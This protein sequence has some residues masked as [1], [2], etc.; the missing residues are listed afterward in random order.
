MK[1]E[2]LINLFIIQII[3]YSDDTAANQEQGRQWLQNT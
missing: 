2:N 3:K 1:N